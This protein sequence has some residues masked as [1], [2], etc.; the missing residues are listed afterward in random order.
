MEKEDQ[1]RIRTL[2]ES[3]ECAV[4]RLESEFRNTQR[5]T[6]DNRFIFAKTNTWLAIQ[7]F[8]SFPSSYSIFQIIQRH[9]EKHDPN[10]LILKLNEKYRSILTKELE[11]FQ[12][13]RSVVIRSK[14]AYGIPPI[15]QN[16]S[17]NE[18]T[19]YDMFDMADLLMFS[20]SCGRTQL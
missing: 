13:M 17:I 2:M 15:F 4:Q 16:T 18:L 12:E 1:V 20:L 6:F 5:C 3:Y 11:L 7:E 19:N 10:E 8:Y 9:C 14:E